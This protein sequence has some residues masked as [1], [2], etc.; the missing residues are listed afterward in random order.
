[1][2]MPVRMGLVFAGIIVVGLATAVFGALHPEAVGPIAAVGIIVGGL[3]IRRITP[4][5]TRGY[6]VLTIVG[7]LAFLFALY[8]LRSR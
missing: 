6:T 4:R 2:S 3:L 5:L 8:I 1:M 7:V